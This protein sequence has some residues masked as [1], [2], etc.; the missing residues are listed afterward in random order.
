LPAELVSAED[1][2]SSA[3]VA[4][5]IDDERRA[6]LGDYDPNKFDPKNVRFSD[7]REA[8][9]LLRDQMRPGVTTVGATTSRSL[10]RGAV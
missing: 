4:A 3:I 5:E 9:A 7:P 1:F 2:A 6:W 10:R 8:L